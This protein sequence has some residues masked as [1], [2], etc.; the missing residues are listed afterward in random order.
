MKA[1][2]AAVT[3]TCQAENVYCQLQLCPSPL[4][5]EE[6]S[7]ISTCAQV[8]IRAERHLQ[9]EGAGHHSLRVVKVNVVAGV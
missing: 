4:A 1:I 5:A 3:L 9:Q 7:P 6:L 2:K 8:A